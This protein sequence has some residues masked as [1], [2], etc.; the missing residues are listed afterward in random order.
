MP[1]TNSITAINRFWL[2]T[3]S[4]FIKARM[5]Q[6]KSIEKSPKSLSTRTVVTASALLLLVSADT[7]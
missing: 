2:I 1:K 4:Q 3:I 5:E 6:N 7:K